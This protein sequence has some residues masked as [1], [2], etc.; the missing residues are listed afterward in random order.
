M[1]ASR[2]LSILILL[3]LR[4]RLTAKA[5]AE[6]FEVSE[7]TIYRDVDSLSAAGV[8][9]YGDRGPGGGFQLLDGYRTRLTGLASDEAEAMLMIGLPGPAAALGLGPAASRARGKLLASLTPGSIDGA[10]RIGA[11]FHLDPVD[12]YRDDQPAE[13]LPRLTRAVLDQRV[14]DM[15][16]ESWTATHDWRI[17]PLGLVMKAGAWYCV[18]AARG[19]TRIFKVAN[20]LSAATLDTVFERPVGFE[21]AAFWSD[22]T[23]RFESGLRQEHAMLR[24]SPVGLKRLARLGGYAVRA[25]QTAGPVEEDGWVRLSLPVERPEQAALDLLAIGPEIEVIDPP[26]LRAALHELA[27]QM[28]DRTAPQV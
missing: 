2:L 28:I 5:L 13:H 14:I 15:R 9:V 6:E 16:Y 21:L 4:T 12:W 11:R 24:A 7:R 18:A 10:A 22:S 25:V 8:P 1:R 23:E 20:I 27:G 17:E 26:A 19:K 3:Q